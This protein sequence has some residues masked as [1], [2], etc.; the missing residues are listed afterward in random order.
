MRFLEGKFLL[1]T[2][3]LLPAHLLFELK[4]A[5]N[6]NC[7]SNSH[8]NRKLQKTYRVKHFN[9]FQHFL[10]HFRQQI[11]EWQRIEG[12]RR[13]ILDT[14]DIPI[15]VPLLQMNKSMN[16][17]MTVYCVEGSFGL[18]SSRQKD[19]KMAMISLT[20]LC[21]SFS[22]IFFL[23]FVFFFCCS[24]VHSNNSWTKLCV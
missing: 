16:K 18:L 12:H 8:I 9:N 19:I 1:S 11:P 15:A 4:S 22:S 5:V 21:R 20:P 6:C 14:F 24:R 3:H 10:Q 13:Y 7:N 23:F 2:R 17:S